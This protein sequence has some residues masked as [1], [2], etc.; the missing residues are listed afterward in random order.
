MYWGMYKT[1]KVDFLDTEMYW[2][3]YKTAKVD[4]LDKEKSQFLSMSRKSTLLDLY[5]T[6][7]LYV[8]KVDFVSLVH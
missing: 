5:I 3:M 4:F 8:E 2:G 7:Y 1:G 6:I